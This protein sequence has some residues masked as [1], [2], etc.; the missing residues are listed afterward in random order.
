MSEDAKQPDLFSFGKRCF[1]EITKELTCY[2][3]EVDP[4]MEVRRG[5]GVLCY[6]DLGDGHIYL[7]LPD[8]SSPIGKLQAMV[9]ASTLAL[10]GEDELF[11]L[12]E[13]FIPHLVAH[14]IAHHLRHKYG[15]FGD[16]KW[17][18]EQIA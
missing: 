18:E 3:V 17:E 12:F 6:Y 15:L 1:A 11:K 16:N 13:L 9:L 8:T 5:R 10:S 4:K 7:A 2:G 14:E